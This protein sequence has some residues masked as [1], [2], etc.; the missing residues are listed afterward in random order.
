GR[1]KTTERDGSKVLKLDKGKYVELGR[2]KTDKIF[3]ILVE[4]GDDVDPAYGGQPGP[5][6]N[7]IA[8]PDPK[9]NNSTDWQPDFNQ[10]HYQDL[11]FSDSKDDNVQSMKKYYEKQSSG[12][13]S[14]EGEVTDWVKVKSNEARYGSN[15]CGASTCSTAW[16]LV[17]DGVTQWVSDEKA[18][19][20]S[21][22][23]IKADLAQ[24]DQWDRYDY[25]GDGDFN[26]P[27]GY[28]D[29]FQIV[30]A[31]EDESAGGGVQGEDALWAHRWYAY[32]TD[33]G[34]TGPA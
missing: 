24:F 26:E 27:D 1:K 2:E 20:K 23:D 25:D 4:F 29:H 31:G 7:Q 21:A 33:Q 30:H 28:I 6:H 9:N 5:L 18:A 22:A 17:R 32:G 15:K 14:V 13:Y 8:E 34:R 11:Y 19:G 16:D 3:T 12:R 10:K